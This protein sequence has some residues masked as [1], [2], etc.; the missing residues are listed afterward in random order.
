[1]KGD[2]VEDLFLTN[3][4]GTNPGG[5][6]GL[7]ASLG[8]EDRGVATPP[9]GICQ[10]AGDGLRS[11]VCRRE[12]GEVAF[13]PASRNLQRISKIAFSR[14]VPV[15]V[16]SFFKSSSN[17]SGLSSSSTLLSFSK[18]KHSS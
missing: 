7:T 13:V 17:L 4:C 16:V 9:R 3:A 10:G 2:A 8:D 18:G 11:T 15:K 1:M 5:A 12:G 14:P 6:N